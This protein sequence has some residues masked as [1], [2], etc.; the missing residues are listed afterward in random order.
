MADRIA[1][2]DASLED[3]RAFALI[4]GLDVD[5]RATRDSLLGKISASGWQGKNIPVAKAET[6]KAEQ[7][8]KGNRPAPYKTKGKVEY[9]GIRI[10]TQEKPGGDEPVPVSV[11]GRALFIPRAVGVA[12]PDHII[13]VLEHA[14]EMVYP[15]TDEVGPGNMGGLKNPRIVRSYPFSFIARHEVE[16]VVNEGAVQKDA[17]A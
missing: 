8:G 9:F 6:P 7:Q 16:F 15:E 11:N 14:E 5:G 2:E 1:L 3:L 17:A 13:E 4:M 12:V 10:D